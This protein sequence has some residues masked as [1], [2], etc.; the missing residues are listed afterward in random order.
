M[1]SNVVSVCKQYLVIDFQNFNFFQAFVFFSLFPIFFLTFLNDVPCPFR[2]FACDAGPA[3]D[4]GGEGK[5]RV[6]YLLTIS[7]PRDN[8]TPIFFKNSKQLK[9]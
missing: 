4:G 1:L 7:T 3:S 2:V 6:L 8:W 9:L 5:K